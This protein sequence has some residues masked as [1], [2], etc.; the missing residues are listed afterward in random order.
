MSVFMN[1]ERNGLDLDE[2]LLSHLGTPEAWTVINSEGLSTELI[3][4][5]F[6]IDVFNWQRAHLREHHKVATPEVL[7]DQFPTLEIFE[8]Q[9]VIGDLIDRLRERYAKNQQREKLSQL[10]DIQ[11]NDPL[12]VPEALLKYGRELKQIVSKKGEIFG[13]GDVD[14]VQKMYYREVLQGPGASL[15]WKELN[16]YF[17]GLRGLNAIIASPKQGK[18]WMLVQQLY[19]NIVQ[20]RAVWLYSLELPAVETTM[21]LYCLAADI[22]FYKYIHQRLDDKDWQKIKEVAEFLDTS[23][24]GTPLYRVVKPPA[25]KRSID[26]LVH[27]A[28]DAGA[29]VIL[30]DQLQ[31]V[32]ADDGINLGSHN[33]TGVYWNVLNKARDYSDD[34][35]IVYAHQFSRAAM[36][37]EE[38]PPMEMAKGSAS[39][40]ET[41]TLALGL[42]ATPDMRRLGQLGIGV[43]AARNHEY[44][45]WLIQTERKYGCSFRIAKRIDLEDD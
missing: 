1:V 27:Q 35:P 24:D 17:Y 3:N 6:V 10:L 33:N 36:N 26:E 7:A 43:L 14:R 25:G 11:K 23:S 44:A 16:D 29:E 5:P 31:Y 13:A 41:A 37:S 2:E 28:R 21:R 20:G 30:I 32:E 18:S 4:D 45:S 8:P 42:W 39:I 22:P 38:L 34:G 12:A 15:G 40:E 19:D 9:T